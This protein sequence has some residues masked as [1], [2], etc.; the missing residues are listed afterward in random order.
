MPTGARG[1]R[2][3]RPMSVLR[4]PAQADEIEAHRARGVPRLL[5]VAAGTRPPVCVDPLEDW[6]RT[7]VDEVDL[8]ARWAALCARSACRKPKIDQHGVL[9]F[10]GQSLP[11]AA[12]EA[13]LVRLLLDSYRSVVSRD[14]LIAHM[15]PHS[16]P[17]QRNALDVRVLRARRR[18]LPLGLVIKTVWSQGYLLDAQQDR[19][20]S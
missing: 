18:L 5:L 14:D 9:R 20:A 16:A 11:L 10:A 6:T 15:W 13:A 17:A 19:E 1:H 4:W 8:R 12:G 7:P 2:T 3:D